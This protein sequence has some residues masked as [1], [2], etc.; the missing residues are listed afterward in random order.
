ML[1]VAKM[2][3]AKPLVTDL[4]ADAQVAGLEIP[5]ENAFYVGLD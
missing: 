1:H 3:C 2:L 4:C 5:T